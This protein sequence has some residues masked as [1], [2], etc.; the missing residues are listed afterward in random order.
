[1][2][3]PESHRSSLPFAVSLS[4]QCG[5]VLLLAIP[6]T[7]QTLRNAPA[8]PLPVMLNI[9]PPKAMEPVKTMH[10]RDENMHSLSTPNRYAKVFQPPPANSDRSNLNATS[11]APDISFDPGSPVG[12]GDV[13]RLSDVLV[14]A[15]SAAT[16]PVSSPAKTETSEH[17]IDVGGKVQAAK[18][19]RQVQPM[20][21][22][23]ARQI[24]VQGVVTLE[25]IIGTDGT[26]QQLRALSGHPMLIPSAVQAVQQ[27]LYSPTVLNG[28]AVEVKTTIEV[29]FTLS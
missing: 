15:G 27:W 5:L 8:F 26:I 28:K 16:M 10:S 19:I 20:Y 3:L 9:Q 29:R 22:A 6:W 13:T 2:L 17:V 21:P 14:R 12:I 25:A 1:M 7:V 24:R 18:L 4:V 11:I 23:L